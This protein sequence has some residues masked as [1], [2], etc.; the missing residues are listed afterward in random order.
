MLI[1]IRDNFLLFSYIL[2]PL[3][4]RKKIK[5]NYNFK[6]FYFFKVAVS[7]LKTKLNSLL[8]LSKLLLYIS[9]HAPWYPEKP[10]KKMLH[11]SEVSIFIGDTLVPT[12]I[13]LFFGIFF[14]D[15]PTHPCLPHSRSSINILG[16][17]E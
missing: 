12:K 5:F 7:F 17:K 3:L 10:W 1:Y 2:I 15:S 14:Q 8:R 9:F 16:I 13:L 4:P 6:D 11:I